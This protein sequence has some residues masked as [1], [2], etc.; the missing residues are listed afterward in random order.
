MANLYMVIKWTSQNIKAYYKKIGRQV[1]DLQLFDTYGLEKH[2]ETLLNLLKQSEKDS[3]ILNM[4]L[5]EQMIDFIYINDLVVAFIFVRQ[6]FMNRQYEYCGIYAVSSGKLI[7]L[8]SLVKVIQE[9]LQ[10]RINITF[11]GGSRN[12]DYVK[13]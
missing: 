6:Y 4:M 13:S 11:G 10:I 9:I 2:R 3:I 12:I 1:I 8:R 7:S 5:E